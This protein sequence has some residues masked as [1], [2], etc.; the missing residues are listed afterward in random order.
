MKLF[1]SHTGLNS[2]LESAHSGTP[3]LSIPLFL[4]QNYNAHV[5]ESRG[6]G[7]RLNKKKI[8]VASLTAAIQTILNN[9]TFYENA[10]NLQKMLEHFPRRPENTLIQWVEY[11]ATF[12]SFGDH[13]QL[14]SANMGFFEYF[15]IDI[16]F[17]SYLIILSSLITGFYL[18]KLFVSVLLGRKVKTE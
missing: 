2:L 3:V 13:I 17:V 5:V 4:D 16:L 7:L 10:R 12:K 15:C 6:V 18:L 9:E 1:I 8:T 11:A 14:Q